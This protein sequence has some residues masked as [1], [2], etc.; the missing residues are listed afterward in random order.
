MPAIASRLPA[1]AGVMAILLLG[2][3]FLGQDRRLPV[4]FEGEGYAFPYGPLAAGVGQSFVAPAPYLSSVM[5]TVDARGISTTGFPLNLRIRNDRGEV[6][7]ESRQL[8]DRA[9][10]SK[11][12]ISFVPIADSKGRLFEI[13]VQ[14]AEGAEGDSY[15][16]M[17]AGSGL[18]G[19]VFR[20]QEGVAG[21]AW[22][23][24]LRLGQ[25]VRPLTFF[26]SIFAADPLTGMALLAVLAL[27]AGSLASALRVLVRARDFNLDWLAAGGL[28]GGLALAVAWAAYALHPVT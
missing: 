16:P 14:P 8:I 6:I 24:N 12:A 15:L 5:V 2:V 13:E 26:R 18:P 21:D 28:G 27:L 17:R 25:T 3:L 23:A 22:S 1:F 4:S 10:I 11:P 20:D 19:E 7:A 9:G